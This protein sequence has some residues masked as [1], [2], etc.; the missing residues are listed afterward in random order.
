[1]KVFFS[2]ANEIKFDFDYITEGQAFVGEVYAG[3]KRFLDILALHL[4][5]SGL[6]AEHLRVEQ[7]YQIIDSTLDEKNFYYNSFK[8]DP[9]SVTK[10]LLKIRDELMLFGF[11]FKVTKNMPEKIKQLCKLEEKFDL[12]GDADIFNEILQN[13]NGDL[14]VKEVVLLNDISFYEPHLIK[15]IDKLKEC[16]VKILS[17]KKIV[18]DDEKNSDLLKFK[19]YLAGKN[20]KNHEIKNDGSLIILKYKNI[21]E[22]SS[23]LAKEIYFSK[24]TPVLYAQNSHDIVNRALC[25]NKLPSSG[26]SLRSSNRPLTQLL[27]LAHVVLWEPIDI[28]R[29]LEFLQLSKGLINKALVSCLEEALSEMPGIAGPCWQKKLS[30]LEES[31][32]VDDWKKY[33]KELS[34][35]FE[36]K[37]IESS[38]ACA[39]EDVIDVYKKVMEYAK[40]HAI[41][42][43]SMD[44]NSSWELYYSCEKLIE[45]LEKRVVYKKHIIKIDLEKIIDDLMPEITIC[46]RDAEV[47][48]LHL[49][50]NSKELF[51][52]T[53]SL[54]WIDL[55]DFSMNK[56]D[57]W[58][59]DEKKYLQSHGVIYDDCLQK[60][61]RQLQSD[62][63][64]IENVTQKL[65]LCVP[66]EPNDVLEHQVYFSLQHFLGDSF[67][68]NIKNISDHIFE[69]TYKTLEKKQK[70]EIPKIVDKWKLKN[71]T[72]AQ[73]KTRESYSSL[74]QLFNY[75]Y[76][77]VME[78]IAELRHV[79]TP[80]L[81]DS[82]LLY[83]SLAH[84]VFESFFK[85]YTDFYSLSRKQI[86]SWYE[87][88]FYKIVEQSA[89]LLLQ[90]DRQCDCEMVKIKIKEA[91]LFLIETLVVNKWEVVS[92]EAELL[93]IFADVDIYGRA[94][95]LLKRKNEVAV[96]DYK[97]SGRGYREKMVFEDNDTQLAIY[98]KLAKSQMKKEIV[99]AAYFI[100][101]SALLIAKN[102]F[103]FKN[104]KTKVGTQKESDRYDDI[105]SRME[106]TYKL[107][108][109]EIKNGDVIFYMDDYNMQKYLEN[110]AL[111]ISEDAPYSN[112]YSSFCGWEDENE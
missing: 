14:V 63:T 47:N 25:L 90:K 5:L 62:L 64:M 13:I 17:H 18:V 112:P 67:F 92:S 16:G 42:E 80:E 44:K 78:K 89:V 55:F 12:K 65:I 27:K 109:E 94:D 111:P 100:I 20:K 23:Y 10:H 95:L 43:T 19:T 106:N 72:K 7:Y 31:A 54:V 45:I 3:P 97:W 85:E 108:K 103:G 2:A 58:S 39:I 79:R 57:F 74:N 40:F 76:I 29:L 1:M 48:S 73:M 70:R 15:L 34:F 35:W 75:P 93:G 82:S 33:K 81:A 96:I 53:K 104:A 6:K 84:T 102:N 71:L 52:Q 30:E 88:N 59:I 68:E 83:G 101:D 51:Y 60:Y 24:E 28:H 11:D 66:E 107:R 110:D 56:N 86:I 69:N 91:L 46:L 36:R 26:L 8:A 32:A 21:Y 99:H 9:L 61:Q 37:R 22:L 49:M 87:K 41:Q 77:W 50:K 98:S 105:F 38:A 4:G